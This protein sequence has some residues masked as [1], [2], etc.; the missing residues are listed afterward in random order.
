MLVECNGSAMC[1]DAFREGRTRK[2]LHLGVALDAQPQQVDLLLQ[3]RNVCIVGFIWGHP[4]AG[5]SY[6][7][8]A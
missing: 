3:L 2:A 7:R 1:A 4:V 5:C 8:Y 6:L